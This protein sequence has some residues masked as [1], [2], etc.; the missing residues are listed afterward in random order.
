MGAVGT[1][2]QDDSPSV[3]LHGGLSDPEAFVEATTLVRDAQG[4]LYAYPVGDP[5]EVAIYDSTGAYLRTIGGFGDGPGELRAPAQVAI[6]PGDSVYVLDRGSRRVSVFD[7]QHEFVRS[8]LLPFHNPLQIAPAGNG[9]LYV[10][11]AVSEGVGAGKLVHLL[12]PNER[13]P[14]WSV[15]SDGQPPLP[16]PW[17]QTRWLMFTG[18]RLITARRNEY[19]IEVWGDGA[20]EPLAVFADSASFRPWTAPARLQSLDDPPSLVLGVYAGPPHTVQVV[21]STKAEDFAPP[22][23]TA[24]G[25]LPAD[26]DFARL[27]DTRV[28]VIDLATGRHVSTQRFDDLV[29]AVGFGKFAR[30]MVSDVGEIGF[31]VFSGI[32]TAP[33]SGQGGL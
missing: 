19:V 28:D 27:R 5:G 24:D 22:R 20:S 15:V 14:T 26:F 32:S 33:P 12:D 10:N 13:Q 25:Q 29:I 21:I 11:A 30:M 6:G 18:T 8:Q 7:P 16:Y 2:A 31:E 1:A 4:R 9:R 17:V 23:L 3:V